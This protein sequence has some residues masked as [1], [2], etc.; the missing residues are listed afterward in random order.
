ME[1]KKLYTLVSEI[2]E[3]ILE[4]QKK[5][6]VKIEIKIIEKLSE[7]LQPEADKLVKLIKAKPETTK[8]HYGEYLRYLSGIKDKL[9]QKAFYQAFLTVGAGQGATDAYNLLNN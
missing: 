1:T 4:Y 7:F 6:D 5:K 2:K 8:G 3:L 9:T